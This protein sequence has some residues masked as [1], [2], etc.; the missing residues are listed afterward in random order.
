MAN[1]RQTKSIV[2]MTNKRFTK[3]INFMTTWEGMGV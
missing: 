2:M 1:I 3:T